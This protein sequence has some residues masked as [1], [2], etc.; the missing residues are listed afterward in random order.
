MRAVVILA[1]LVA[2]DDGVASPIGDG[3]GLADAGTEGGRDGGRRDAGAIDA[4]APDAGFDA[5]SP[6]MD[7][8]PP[9]PDAALPDDCAAGPLPEPIPGCRPTPVPDTG[10]PY[11]D[12]VARINQ[13]RAEC[14]C[15]PPLERWNEGEDCADMQAEYDAN[16][17]GPHGG[18]RANICS[19]RGSAQN[20]CPGWRSID[21]VIDG[22][23]QQMWDEGPGEPFSEHGHYINMSSTRYRRVACGFFTTAGG[24]IWAVQN[25]Q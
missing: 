6:G 10:D 17:G 23:L 12:C 22:C 16:G 21:Q 3:G 2:C 4:A 14:Q 1:L 15:L 18:F 25:F 11:V 13:F 7:S 19:P 24:R 5:S 8:G 20:E 9:P